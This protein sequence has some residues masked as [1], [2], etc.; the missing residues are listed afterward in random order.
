MESVVMPNMDDIAFSQSSDYHHRGGIWPDA[1]RHEKYTTAN[2]DS[3]HSAPTFYAEENAPSTMLVTPASLSGEDVKAT[4]KRVVSAEELNKKESSSSTTDTSLT[5]AATTATLGSG[6]S[7]SQSAT[8]RRR[9]WFST[10]AKVESIANGV[11]DSLDRGRRV[12]NATPSSSRST[13]SNSDAGDGPEQ[14]NSQFLSPP[15]PPP[16]PPRRGSTATDKAYN[17]SV[18]PPVTP[19]IPRTNTAASN[20]PTPSTSFFSTLKARAGD[21]QALSNSAKEAMKKW[22]ANWGASKRETPESGH[23]GSVYDRYEP[24]N[25]DYQSKRSSYAVVRRNVEDRNRAINQ[26]DVVVADKATNEVG[27]VVSN[28]VDGRRQREMRK[29][30]VSGGQSGASP[31]VDESQRETPIEPHSL[32]ADEIFR[33]DMDQSA[34]LPIHTQPPQPRMMTIPGIHASHKGEVM[35]MGYVAEPPQ[36][37]EIKSRTPGIQSVYRLWKNP[38]SSN[39]PNQEA[40]PETTPR[41]LGEPINEPLHS[42]PNSMPSSPIP[43]PLPPRS[44]SA[45][46][47]QPV[48]TPRAVDD[49]D[50]GDNDASVAPELI[51]TQTGRNPVLLESNDA[52]TVPSE[53]DPTS[54]LVN[55]PSTILT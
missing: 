36:S 43:P 19:Q 31:S 42:R 9:T 3:L 29:L 4:L 30:S 41:A 2:P 28:P 37:A 11:P 49:S 38:T 47:A 45:T 23:D 6:Q 55:P 18:T 15:N 25:A 40:E 24:E 14:Q 20:G 35:S 34:P 21:K 12:N 8:T 13:S 17:S 22:S 46:I 10:S 16:L 54:I 26:G 48:D 32:N 53:A 44:R 51:G 7:P 5:R 33:A 1:V 52:F 27:R 39:Q 50:A